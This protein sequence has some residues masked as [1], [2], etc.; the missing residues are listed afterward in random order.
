[1]QNNS[2]SDRLVDICVI[3]IEIGVNNYNK[4]GLAPLIWSHRGVYA[5]SVKNTTNN[6]YKLMRLPAQYAVHMYSV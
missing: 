2:W 3:L 6:N 5:S 4:I 1:M